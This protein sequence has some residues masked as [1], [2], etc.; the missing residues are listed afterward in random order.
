M[1]SDLNGNFKLKV[2]RSSF[3]CIAGRL[4]RSWAVGINFS[5][6]LLLNF[7]WVN[8]F[9]DTTIHV[10]SV[11][12][13]LFELFRKACHSGLVSDFNS[14]IASLE[15]LRAAPPFFWSCSP[16]AKWAQRWAK[17]YW[18]LEKQQ[19]FRQGYP[20]CSWASQTTYKT[21]ERHY[22]TTVKL[23]FK[24]DAIHHMVQIR[25]AGFSANQ[26]SSQGNLH[27]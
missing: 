25:K 17:R 15:F 11:G 10:T 21:K 4:A 7:K 6:N 18:H 26:C 24:T 2:V 22:R 12:A 13:N 14:Y 9:M 27:L 16:P 5:G 23:P 3:F 20:D 1:A 19:H 8:N